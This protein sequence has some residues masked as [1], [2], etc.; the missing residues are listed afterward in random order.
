VVLRII[1]IVCFAMA[2]ERVV[3]AAVGNVLEVGEFVKFFDQGVGEKQR[4]CINDHCFMRGRDAT[5]HLYGITHTEPFDPRYGSP[6]CH[7]TASKLTQVPWIKNP[8][9]L[10]TEPKSGE[11]HL[12]A[13]HVVLHEGTYY[14]YYCAG[15]LD[16]TKYR[17]HLATSRNLNKWTRYPENPLFTD[18]Y[19]ARDPFVLRVGEKWVMYYTATSEPAGGNHVVACKTSDDLIHWT[20]RTIVFT[21]PRVG[22]IG[23]PTES[24]FV[25]RRA[26][27][28]YLFIGPRGGYVGTDVFRSK[29]P[30]KWS[31]ED[32]VAHIKSHAAEVVRDVDG[33]WYVSHAGLGQRGVYLAPL[34]WNDRLDDNDTSMPVP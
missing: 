15:N 5:W 18:G 6:F 3:P 31:I 17:I 34:R 33:K 24:P 19:A 27:F 7:A 25:V 20:G 1:L 10:I 30:F 22:T 23:G 14:M 26:D 2:I 12:W 9:A 4:W 11:I 32:K 13:P 8:F 21:D 28:Y 29:D 16:P